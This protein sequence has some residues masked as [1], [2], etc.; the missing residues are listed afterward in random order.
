MNL[1]QLLAMGLTQEQAEKILADAAAELEKK[2]SEIEAIK[3]NRDEILREKKAL[4]DKQDALDAEKSQKEQENLKSKGDIEALEKQYKDLIAQKDEAIANMLKANNDKLID[5]TAK[6]IATSLAS[7][8]NN[9]NLLKTLIQNR[10]TVGDNG[11]IKVL[12][13]NG[14]L[15]INTVDQLKNEIKSCGLYDSLITGTHASGVGAQGGNTP[16]GTKSPA[17]YTE[18]ERVDLFNSNPALFKQL[19]T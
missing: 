10:I 18:K 2:Q 16:T 15:S 9:A 3:S 6:D 5:A 1:E 13:A 4:K 11:E 12:D 19:F 8:A 17:D 14:Q 7:N